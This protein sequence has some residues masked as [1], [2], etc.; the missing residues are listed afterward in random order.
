MLGAIDDQD[1]FAADVESPPAQV[2]GDRG[3]V[4]SAPAM[5]LIAQERIEVAGPGEVAQCLA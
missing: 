2:T 5:W 4:L 3:P 1:S